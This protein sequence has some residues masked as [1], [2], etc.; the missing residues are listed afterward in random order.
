MSL[1]FA[2]ALESFAPCFAIL[3]E[4][5]DGIQVPKD[6]SPGSRSDDELGINSKHPEAENIPLHAQTCKRATLHPNLTKR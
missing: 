5:G 4:P 3:A 1:F 2:A 6:D